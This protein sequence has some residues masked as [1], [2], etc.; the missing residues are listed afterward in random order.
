RNLAICQANATACRAAQA[1]AG[2]P[3]SAAGLPPGT[4][5]QTA[6]TFQNWGLA[7]Q[8]PLTIF[9]RF[10]FASSA[11]SLPN[12]ATVIHQQYANTGFIGN[13]SANNIGTLASTLAFSPTYRANRENPALGIPANFFVANPNAAFAR[14]LNND[15][16]S[17]YH[18]LEVEVRR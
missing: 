10:F 8:V 17:N 4:I 2:I 9:D 13:L 18:A 14:V 15:S 16:M 7:G 11:G 1:A 12:I 5:V 3:A 6:N